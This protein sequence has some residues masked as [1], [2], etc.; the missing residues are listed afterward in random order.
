[1]VLAYPTHKYVRQGPSSNFWIV[2]RANIEGKHYTCA[3]TL[4]GI[5]GA[6]QEEAVSGRKKTMCPD[7]THT[8][9]WVHE[10]P[11]SRY[12]HTHTRN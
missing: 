4:A 1:M 10:G 2:R 6:M 8:C 7:L 3:V 11:V 9:V 5:F 12:T